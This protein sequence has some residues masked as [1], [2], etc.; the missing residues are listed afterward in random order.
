MKNRFELLLVLEPRETRVGIQWAEIAYG[1]NNL[2]S[3]SAGE[4][5][6]ISDTPGDAKPGSVV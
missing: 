5:M 6:C 3:G 2:E 1:G 4:T